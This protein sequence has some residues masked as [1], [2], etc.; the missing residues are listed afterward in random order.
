MNNEQIKCEACQVFK[1]LEMY[2]HILHN[3]K[4][5]TDEEIS[6][7][8]ERRKLEKQL[9]LE[10]DMEK[11]EDQQ[12]ALQQFWFMIS[13]DWLYRWKC[14]V[15]NKNSHKQQVYHDPSIVINKSENDRIGIL[16]P[17][18]IS[19]E[20]LFEKPLALGMNAAPEQSKLKRNL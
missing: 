6:Q 11:V 1:P 7:L 15:S 20:S 18:P 2:K 9:I 8:N 4:N 5:V 19:N 12:N 16:P 3:P 17:G 13:S 14:F 10:R